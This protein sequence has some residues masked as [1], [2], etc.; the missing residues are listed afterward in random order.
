MTGKLETTTRVFNKVFSNGQKL[1][2]RRRRKKLAPQTHWKCELFLLGGGGAGPLRVHFQLCGAKVRVLEQNTNIIKFWLFWGSFLRKVG[3]EFMGNCP[4]ILPAA[5]SY[6][7][8]WLPH[9]CFQL[10]SITY[11]MLLRVKNN[12]IKMQPNGKTPPMMIPGAA[13]V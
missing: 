8:P 12:W 13:R 5:G 6:W 3:G 7:E 9:D 10:S 1:W 2:S 4:R 11:Q